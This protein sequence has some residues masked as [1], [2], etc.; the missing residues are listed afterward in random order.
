[1]TFVKY[2]HVDQWNRWESP[3]LNSSVY[4]QLTYDK[5]AKNIH[6]ERECSSINGVGKTGQP[7][8]KEWTGSVSYSI[9]WGLIC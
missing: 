9:H 4:G 7:H 3:G 8:V 1:M 6:G 5:G 2:R